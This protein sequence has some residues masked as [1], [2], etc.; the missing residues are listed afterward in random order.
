MQHLLFWI[1]FTWILATTLVYRP[2]ANTLGLRLSGL[3]TLL[4]ITAGGLLFPWLLGVGSVE[5]VL[6]P[7]FRWSTGWDRFRVAYA[8]SAPRCRVSSIAHG[9]VSNV[10]VRAT[11]HPA[12]LFS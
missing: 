6:R 8:A 5:V 12:K 7:P 4:W 3:R 10:G 1:A 11:V 2:D 9:W